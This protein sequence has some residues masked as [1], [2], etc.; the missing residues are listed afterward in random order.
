MPREPHLKLVAQPA[1]APA[2]V[3][4]RDDGRQLPETPAQKALEPGQD[5]REP[6]PPAH[7]HHPH[8]V[9]GRRLHPPS[10]RVHE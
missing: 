3:R 5:D 9:P 8:P 7:G 10:L 1:G 4:H 2:V 6:R